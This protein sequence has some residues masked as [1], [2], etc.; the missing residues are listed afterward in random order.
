MLSTD[1][2]FTPRSVLPHDPSGRLLAYHRAPA[3]LLPLSGAILSLKLWRA[4]SLQLP[5]YGVILAGR[6]SICGTDNVGI[7]VGHEV[8]DHV[9]LATE[10]CVVGRDDKQTLRVVR[11]Y[12]RSCRVIRV[13][14]T[15]LDE[16][17]MM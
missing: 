12:G 14:G 4:V 13:R 2:K 3:N 16:V 11:L 1:L 5:I 10:T 9:D 8:D 17:T 15:V 7:D 6:N